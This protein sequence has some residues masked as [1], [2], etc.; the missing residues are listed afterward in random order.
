[1][2]EN[3]IAVESARR[4]IVLDP[5]NIRYLHH[6]SPKFGQEG[7]AEVLRVRVQRFAERIGDTRDKD[8]SCRFPVGDERT[9]IKLGRQV[10][11][12]GLHHQVRH[13]LMSPVVRSPLEDHFV[14][15]GP[16]RHGR[17]SVPSG[18]DPLAYRGTDAVASCMADVVLSFVVSCPVMEATA[19]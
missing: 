17:V 11:S 3:V 1:M 7:C 14:P 16:E 12:V 5:P 15:L 4:T 6:A 10:L 9:Q 19:D 18:A 8:L 2:F 13:S